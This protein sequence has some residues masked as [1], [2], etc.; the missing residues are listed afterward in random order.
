VASSRCFARG[1]A[2]A[3]LPSPPVVIVV[4]VIISSL[5]DFPVVLNP[6]TS[7]NRHIAQFCGVLGRTF[8]EFVKGRGEYCQAQHEVF[9]DK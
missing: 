9:A 6:F 7:M 2:R 4:I 8:M 5:R 1:P 3:S